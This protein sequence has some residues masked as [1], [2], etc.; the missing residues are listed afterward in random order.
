MNAKNNKS[1]LR[2]YLW[3]SIALA[4]IVVS[5]SLENYF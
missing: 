2:S 5:M 1:R 3:L 4:L